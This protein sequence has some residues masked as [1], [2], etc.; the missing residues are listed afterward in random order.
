VAWL[1]RLERENG[2]LVAALEWS[3]VAGNDGDSA[4][5]TP[6]GRVEAG[7]KLARGLEYFW[8][9]RGR[10][11]ENLSR[12]M[13]LLALTAP[14]TSARALGLIV[15][16]YVRGEML[17]DRAGAVDMI[18]EALRIWRNLGDGH[19]VAVAL[20]RRGRL[21]LASGD[22]DLAM[23]AF[24]EAR[25]RFRELGQTSGVQI[26]I[27]LELAWAAH[28]QGELDT[29]QA[30]YDEA[31]L[32]S[33]TLDDSHSIALTLQG[34]GRL[35]RDQGT[36][37]QSVTLFCQ[38][39]ALLAPL[40]DLRCA[41]LCLVDLCRV[42]CDDGPAADVTRLLGAAEALRE[43]GGVP[44]RLP[45]GAAADPSAATLRERIDRQTFDAAWSEGRGMSLEQA[46]A[47][48]LRV[49]AQNDVS[50]Q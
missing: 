20:E 30:W 1:D 10:G 34:L 46:V 5:A 45:H 22:V 12:V 37:A 7:L 23:A 42:L 24:T 43:V 15:T 39:L 36:P 38:S 33:R 4:A 44:I 50:V 14:E 29:A 8:M 25:D 31:L 17:G 26:P 48:A 47:H 2:N 41:P 40:G 49:A 11:R 35:R 13:K 16:G 32:E 6:G 3:A 27:T 28:A 18:D 9:V 19:G 21:A